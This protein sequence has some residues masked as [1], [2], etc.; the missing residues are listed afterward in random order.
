MDKFFEWAWVGAATIIA[1]MIIPFITPV[2]GYILF[3]VMAIAADT[4]TGILAAHKTN[5]KITSKGIWRSIEKIVIAGLA[6]MLCHGFQTL[7][8]DDIPLTKGV[9]AIIAFA[10][11]KSN[12]ENY[13][14]IT[15]VEVGS[16]ILDRVKEIIMPVLKSKNKS[17][18][19]E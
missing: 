9:S 4:I 14:K 15:G 3:M 7:F 10:E 12:L 11:L 6:I 8:L 13:K 2:S 1:E 5:E 17:Q 16:L 19:T 18:G